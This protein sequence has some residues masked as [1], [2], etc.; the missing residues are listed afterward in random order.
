MENLIKVIKQYEKSTGKKLLDWDEGE[1]FSFLK[2]YGSSDNMEKL[3]YLYADIQAKA[4]MASASLDV[5]RGL[6]KPLSLDYVSITTLMETVKTMS[7]KS[8]TDRD[9]YIFALFILFNSGVEPDNVCEFTLNDF[10]SLVY[11]PLKQY[12]YVLERVAN[13]KDMEYQ[14]SRISLKGTEEAIIKRPLLPKKDDNHFFLQYCDRT[15]R[16]QLRQF[17]IK[18]YS[19][20]TMILSYRLN[21]FIYLAMKQGLDIKNDIL[22]DGRYNEI[23]DRYKELAIEAGFINFAS[24]KTRYKGSIYYLASDLEKWKND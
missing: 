7:E 2:K 24:L 14:Q 3:K 10:D 21:K 23:D 18:N 12:R 8:S 5:Y 6:V 11:N 13:M 4:A 1:L 17:G 16:R 19:N 22:L 20:R 15:V 9:Y